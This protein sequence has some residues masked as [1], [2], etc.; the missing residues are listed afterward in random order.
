MPEMGEGVIEATVAQWLKG[1]GDSVKQYE[2]VLEIETDKVTTEATAEVSG[3]LLKVFVP[4]GTTVPVGTLLAV[5]GKAGEQWDDDATPTTTTTSPTPAAKAEKPAH[6]NGQPAATYSGW[7]SPVVRRMAAEHQLNLDLITGSG[8]DG[9]ITKQDVIAYLEARQTEPTPAPPA[10]PPA[11]VAPLP[12]ATPKP[13]AVTVPAGAE[14]LPLTSIRR[15]IADHMVLSKH[16]SPHVTTVFEVDF[17]AVAAHRQSNKAIFARDGANLTFTPYLVIA[18]AQA[19]RQHPLVNS[20]WGENGIVLKRD[21]NIGVA[22]AIPDGL[23][24][25]VV[26]QADNYN[27]LGLARMINDLAERARKKMLRPEEVQNGTF[28]ITNH[29]VSGSLFATPIINQ[30][31]CAILGVGKIEKR[32]K[33]INDAIAIRP[34]AYVSL[35]FDHRILDG[36]SADGFVATVKAILENWQ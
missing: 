18:S 11:V 23:I 33:V 35:T 24:V 9:R 32:V 25:P 12:T 34:L 36:A 1:E 5:I 27:L 22:A 30:P 10:P 8:R 6:T 19:L 26:K 4:A 7:V 14:I 17:A 3:I 20:S 28:T 15:A 31:Q 16:T 29:G 2:P 13:T 21:I